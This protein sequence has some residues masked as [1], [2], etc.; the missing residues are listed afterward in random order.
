MIYKNPKFNHAYDISLLNVPDNIPN[1]Y[2]AEH[3]I[4]KPY[5]GDTVY[6]I[7]FPYFST[8]S[9]KIDSPSVYDGRITKLSK[10]MI[11]TDVNVQAGKYMISKLKRI[12]K[13]QQIKFPFFLGQSGCP[14][15]NKDKKLL[16]VCISNSKDSVYNLVYPNISM[17]VPIFEIISILDN[18]SL[19]GG[20]WYIFFFQFY[21]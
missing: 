17:A 7:G 21:L 14:L 15:F 18:Y 16:G 11:L 13:K 6:S 9:S 8:F 2:F 19:L 4:D 10:G 3:A 20:E 5:I 12:S 1:H